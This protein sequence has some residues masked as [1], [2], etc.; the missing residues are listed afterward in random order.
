MLQ[1][2]IS[3]VGTATNLYGLTSAIATGKKVDRILSNLD[4]L[5]LEIKKL[6]DKIYYCPQEA[7][8]RDI[9]YN[10]PLIITDEKM[11]HDAGR[12]LEKAFSGKILTSSIIQTPV[13]L[14]NQIHSNP[15]QALE[16]I[17][18]IK[19]TNEI[20]KPDHIPL[21]FFESDIPFVGWKNINDTKND[22]GFTYNAVN[23]I[24]LPTNF[25]KSI[26][27]AIVSNKSIEDLF[28]QASRYIEK[29]LI[30]VSGHISWQIPDEIDFLRN[31]SCLK[32]SGS[33]VLAHAFDKNTLERTNVTLGSS[34]YIL[35]IIRKDGEDVERNDTLALFVKSEHWE[36]FN[37][38]TQRLC[39]K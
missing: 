1:N 32:F 20:E 7:I 15:W 21:L 27:Q 4:G 19:R 29:L 26:D 23:N 8:I 31:T 3:V 5:N 2:L 30:S 38:V 36:V 17:R 39:I 16:N 33:K 25:T 28:N 10:R 18:P 6:S 22:F 13:K 24:W 35:R 34:G 9:G 12:L 14:K 37:K 11:V